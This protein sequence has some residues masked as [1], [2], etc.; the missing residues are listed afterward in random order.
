LAFMP[1]DVLIVIPSF[2]RRPLLAECLESIACSLEG[3][4]LKG[5]TV[6]VD[7]ASWDESAALVRE[8]YKNVRLI[9]NEINVGFAAACNQGGQSEDSR[10]V[11]LMN[12]DATLDAEAIGVLVAYADEESSVG[13]ITGRLLDLQGKE[14]YPARH[15][16]DRFRP[17]S[18][19]I[20]ALSWVP[21]TCVLLRRE[22]LDE[23]GWLDENFFFYN[24]DLDLS[25]RLTAAVAASSLGPAP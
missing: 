17:P 14:H 24:E 3:S 6:V 11:L 16:G 18:K 25:W 13:A 10:Y 23:V 5:R 20:H 1:L 22:A 2:N 4:G 19:K 7:N 15:L 9:A 8:R 21:G 12:N